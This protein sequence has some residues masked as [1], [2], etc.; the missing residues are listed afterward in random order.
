MFGSEKNL[1]SVKFLEH[2]KK[3]WARKECKV[4]EKLLGQGKIWRSGKKIWVRGK[5]SVREKVTFK[6]KILILKNI[7]G[8]EKLLG[9]G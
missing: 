4:R 9:L 3:N 5:N 6:D 1:E 2:T 7:L 8:S